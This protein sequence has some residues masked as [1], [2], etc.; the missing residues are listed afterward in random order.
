VHYN[1]HILSINDREKRKM[2]QLVECIPNFSDARRPEVI[3][4]IKQSIQSVP[5][6]IL[7]DQHSDLDHNRTVITFIGPPQPV[8][9]A[10]YNAIATAAQWINLD[11]HTGEHPRIGS[12]DVVPF[13]PIS[14]VSMDD[15]VEMARRLSKR[16]GQ[17]L[18]IPVYLYE[19]AAVRPDRK[20]L[21]DIRRGQYE[22][23]KKEI[24]TDP[25][26]EPDFGPAELGTA[27]A[28]VIGARFPLIAYNIYLATDDVSIAQKIAK[29]V[30]HSSGGLRFVKAMG[31]L[32]DGRAQVSMNLTNFRKTPIARVVEMVR[33]EAGRYGVA[34]HHS[35]L[36]GLTPQDA[37]IDTAVWYTQLDAFEPS[38]L[39]ES[40]I[41]ETLAKKESPE[42][43]QASFLDRL[44]SV[45]P[46]PGGG[47]AA[48]HTAAAAA[49][50]VAMV[51]RLTIG[52]KKY[53]EVESIMQSTLEQAESLRTRLTKA[54]DEDAAAF[55]SFM[56]A[57]KMP[58]DTPEQIA[59]R[60]AAIQ[61]GTEDSI[62]V[63]LRVAQMCAEVLGLA[64]QVA[65]LGNLN[66]ISD[67]GSAGSLAFAALQS[68][69]MNVQI[70]LQGL[71]DAGLAAQHRRDLTKFGQKAKSHLEELSKI[72]K[73]RAN[74]DLF[75]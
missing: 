27:G 37:L 26:R 51:S 22:G 14:E 34:I 8:E 41:F 12:T 59:T 23:L 52:R 16:V 71:E 36:V 7:L 65:S 49:A 25:N 33:R 35:E 64:L 45:D 9:T 47:S 31:V 40:R 66:A 62:A 44:A 4:K 38:Q 39:L 63:P 70:N 56:T 69:G 58:K 48:A 15:C 74:I 61:R 43:E 53:A 46:V 32:V 54:V 21:E 28:T 5:E 19:E 42:N 55:T 11:E 75:K 2:A 73:E 6:I 1:C 29:A 18:S 10:A 17:E 57:M 60:A 13:V 20:N 72:L 68:A 30:R 24:K 3:E 67:A 50:L